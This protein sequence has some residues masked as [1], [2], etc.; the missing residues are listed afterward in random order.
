MKLTKFDPNAWVL[1][2]LEDVRCY[3]PLTAG[4][5][6]LQTNGKLYARAETYRLALC[7]VQ[8]G[9]GA[10]GVKVD[11][12]QRDE[13]VAGWVEAAAGMARDGEF[14]PD[15][16]WAVHDDDLAPLGELDPRNPLAREHREA[17][18]AASASAV[19]ARA[20]A[21]GGDGRVALADL[22][23]AA[24]ALAERLRAEGATI[25][26]VDHA[27]GAEVDDAGIDAERLAALAAGDATGDAAA[28]SA[29]AA[30]V[31]LLV[32]P[33]RLRAVTHG[34]ADTIRARHVMAVGDQTVATKALHTLAR[35]GITVWPD[36]VANLGPVV[37]AHRDDTDVDALLAA[38]HQR[39]AEVADGAAGDE[40]GPVVGACRLAEEHLRTWRGELPFG[41][42]LP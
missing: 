22:S 31:D 3:G 1:R 39:A 41:R 9:G 19:A 28:G 10:G 5:N 6:V 24:L 7:G 40:D 30:E 14:H 42:P 37:A 8:A 32:V 4:P 23:P 34:D 20:L 33:G 25:V 21:G 13:A 27:G 15:P 26:A 16:G 2:D 35:R 18:V 29:R 17:L 38:A 11:R 12:T 36:F